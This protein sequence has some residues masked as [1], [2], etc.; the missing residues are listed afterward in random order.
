MSTNNHDTDRALP[1]KPTPLRN[2]QVM[3]LQPCPPTST[4]PP[5]IDEDPT[6][7]L[8]TINI[9]EPGRFL[10]HRDHQNKA[11]KFAVR[12]TPTIICS[13][14]T[15]IF[16]APSHTADQIRNQLISH[17]QSATAI[18]MS[19]RWRW[20]CTVLA[21]HRDSTAASL[22]DENAEVL[23]S[24]SRRGGWTWSFYLVELWRSRR[25]LWETTATPRVGRKGAMRRI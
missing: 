20:A 12:N 2:H 1:S 8:T 22:D 14:A 3:L 18:D 21:K 15:A 19:D 10:T 16:I 23:I 9:V 4:A 17:I 11:Q 24:A 6:P 25:G 13:L 7:I 5:P